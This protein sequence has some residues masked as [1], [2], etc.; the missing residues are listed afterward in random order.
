MYVYIFLFSS[1]MLPSLGLF[2]NVSVDV[3]FNEVCVLLWNYW[4]ISTVSIQATDELLTINE[5]AI[6]E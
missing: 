6:S 5:V 2:L 4:V 1:L 3:R